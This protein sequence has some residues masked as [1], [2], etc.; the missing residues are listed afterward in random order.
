MTNRI[1]LLLAEDE[2]Q[3]LILLQEALEEGGFE[4]MAAS[5]GVEAMFALEQH[6]TELSG[7]ITDVRVGEGPDGW[8]LGHRAREINPNLPVIYMTADSAA[9]WAVSGVPKSVLLQKP[10]ATA[11]LVAAISNLLNEVSVAPTVPD[12]GA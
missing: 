8:L 5:N 4:V 10:F 3:L 2:A 1:L 9:D 6:N 11:Q 12:L 7:L